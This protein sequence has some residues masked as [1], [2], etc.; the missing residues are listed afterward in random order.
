MP[1]MNSLRPCNLATFEKIKCN[2]S[3][4]AL[5]GVLLYVQIGMKSKVDNIFQKK[6]PRFFAFT[7]RTEAVFKISARLNF[8][9]KSSSKIRKTSENSISASFFIRNPTGFLNFKM[10]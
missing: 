7:Y 1:Q 2:K 4:I 3:L 5:K 10:Q 8:K 6:C 9:C